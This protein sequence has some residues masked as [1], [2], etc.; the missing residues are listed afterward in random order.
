MALIP[1]GS[2]TM[3]DVADNN[4]AGNAA[5]ITVYVSAFYLDQTDVTEALWQTV[6]NWAITH[7]YS[8]DYADREGGKPSG[9][10]D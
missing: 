7:G 3:G 4:E 10:D 2:F 6:Y 1:A 5:P 9:A 8:F